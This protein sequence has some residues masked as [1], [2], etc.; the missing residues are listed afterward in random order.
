[1]LEFRHLPNL[2]HRAHWSNHRSQ[3]RRTTQIGSKLLDLE[4]R[5]SLEARDVRGDESVGVEFEQDLSVAIG[6][7]G[8]IDRLLE[9]VE[10]IHMLDGRGE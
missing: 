10:G 7:Q 5:G 9:L 2:R 1:M 3:I 8:T 6:F 4:K